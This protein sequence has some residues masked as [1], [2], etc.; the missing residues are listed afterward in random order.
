ML[1]GECD[2]TIELA[3]KGALILYM[4]YHL[5]TPPVRNDL[6]IFRWCRVASAKNIFTSQHRN[7]QVRILNCY[8]TYIRLLFN[9]N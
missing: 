8:R 6:I 9:V 3:H 2:E 7:N 4:W 1:V 5:I